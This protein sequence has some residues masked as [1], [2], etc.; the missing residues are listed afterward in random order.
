MALVLAWAWGLR[1]EVIETYSSVV[2]CEMVSG[3]AIAPFVVFRCVTVCSP[4]RY[5]TVLIKA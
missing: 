5:A 2:F 1:G 4:G 3:L